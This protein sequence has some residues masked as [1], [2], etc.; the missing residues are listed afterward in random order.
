MNCHK[1]FL[2]SAFSPEMASCVNSSYLTHTHTP[3]APPSSSSPS[4][5]GREWEWFHFLLQGKLRPWAAPTSTLTPPLVQAR[6]PMVQGHTQY[7][8]KTFLLNQV[9]W[10][11]V[12]AQTPMD[13]SHTHYW[14]NI[15]N[16][17]KSPAASLMLVQPHQLVPT[18]NA[19]TNCT[20]NLTKTN[21][22]THQ[23][24]P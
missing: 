1:H 11:M 17:D 22:M 6:T 10:Y 16:S 18:A 24:Q 15:T 7:R 14:C 3:H 4:A 19:V 20:N 9:G 8:C 5:G 2:L 21:T 13:Q 12:Q 23:D